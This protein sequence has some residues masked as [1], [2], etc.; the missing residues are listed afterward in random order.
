MG[1]LAQRPRFL[2]ISL[3]DA[4]EWGHR[5]R[6]EA[7][8]STL[9]R[10]DAWLDQLL[11]RLR[12]MDGYGENT[13]VIVTTDHGRGDGDSWTSHGWQHPGARRIFAFAIGP[14]SGAQLPGP[15]VFTHRAIRPTIEA[16]LGLSPHGTVL[17]GVL[18]PVPAGDA[19]SALASSGSR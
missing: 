18:P 16:A 15:A 12:T 7:Y 3:N 9:R 1:A 19:V 8:L 6:R 4:D 11:E 5:G 17:P 10:Y 13:T 2:W 14:G